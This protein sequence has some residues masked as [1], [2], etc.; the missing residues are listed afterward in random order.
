M[1]WQERISRR[2]G[3]VKRGRKPGQSFSK[4]KSAGG[5]ENPQPYPITPVSTPTKPQSILICTSPN[6]C[7]YARDVILRYTKDSICVQSAESTTPDTTSAGLA[8]HQMSEKTRQ[9]IKNYGKNGEDSGKRKE[10]MPIR[11]STR[12]RKKWGPAF[13]RSEEERNEIWDLWQSGETARDIAINKK[14]T[15]DTVWGILKREK[16]RRRV[17]EE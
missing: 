14:L 10:E 2:F 7:P 5:V 6:A 3:L 4:E 1:T 13:K 15:M 12:I 11:K 8:S 17:Q 9:L 16:D